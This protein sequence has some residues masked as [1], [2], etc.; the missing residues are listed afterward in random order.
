MAGAKSNTW[1][2]GLMDLLFT[3][4]D[5]EGVG[6]SGGL[7]GSAG[8]GSLYLSLHTSSPGEAGTQST[9]EISY[10]GYAREAVARTDSDWNCGDGLA[11]LLTAVAFTESSGGAGG[12][13]TYVG[14]GTSISGA[15]KLLYYGSIDPTITVAAGVTPEIP[16]SPASDVRET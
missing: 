6:D 5:F 13:A 15:G 16:A 11:R 2:T 3:N 14:I 10:T 4:I 12:T 9:N 8:V 1:E 7:Q